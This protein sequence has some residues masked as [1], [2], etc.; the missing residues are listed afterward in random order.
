MNSNKVS[1]TYHIRKQ[2]N[3]RGATPVINNA[4]LCKLQTT[5]DSISLRHLTDYSSLPNK[6]KAYLLTQLTSIVKAF[7]QV[8]PLDT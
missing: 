8:S 6:I 4:D 7:L 2:H 1:R 3:S 5:T